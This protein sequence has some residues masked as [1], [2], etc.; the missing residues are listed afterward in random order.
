[1]KSFD[2]IILEEPDM[3]MLMDPSQPENVH[4]YFQAYQALI[5]QMNMMDQYIND[6]DFH[7]AHLEEHK[8]E[9]IFNAY[10]QSLQNL[11]ATKLSQEILS[12]INSS[13]V[14]LKSRLSQDIYITSLKRDVIQS[15]FN[16]LKKKTLSERLTYRIGYP[17]ETLYNPLQVTEY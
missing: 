17:K 2:P 4:T 8:R 16:T 14:Y 3:H 12:C 9:R 7:N 5:Q 13:I 11:N 1:M 10:Q 15:T 6:Y